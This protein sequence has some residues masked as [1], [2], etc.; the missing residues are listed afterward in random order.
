MA[1]ANREG[2]E[3]VTVMRGAE[4][5]ALP[6]ARYH[7]SF[8]TEEELLLPAYAGSAWRGALGHAL[9]RTVCVTREPVCDR[10]LLYTSCTYAYVFETPPAPGASKMRK[11]NAVPHPFV[12][13]VPVG[14]ERRYPEG[15]L[16]ELGMT[17]FGRANAQLPYLIHAFQALGRDG[18]GKARSRLAL[19][20]VAQ[21]EPAAA[22]KRRMLYEPGGAFTAPT[23]ESP[24]IPDPPGGC[25]ID[26]LT[27]LR[28]KVDGHNTRAENL[29]FPML[30]GNLLRRISMLTAFH[31]ETPLETDFAGLMAEAREVSIA[32][33]DL[34][35]ME[36]TRYSSRQKTTMQMGG[37]VGRIRI[38]LAGHERLWP[39]LY[40]GQW[41]HAGK[42]T[43]MGLGRLEIV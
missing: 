10:C 15:S 21:E 43:S 14:Q 8:R 6:V 27:P 18:L 28:L 16:L 4:T 42:G 1:G 34:R 37:L 26:F 25:S 7:L 36:W 38:D 2:D 22:G 41:T 23:V 29:A 33:A 12:L 9:K 31:T 13:R 3:A 35:W 39:Y 32:E 19:T 40:L 11:Y 20:H 24:A 17:V 5:P 30:F